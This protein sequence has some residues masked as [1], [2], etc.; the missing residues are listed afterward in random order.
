MNKVVDL[1]FL[2][3]FWEQRAVERKPPLPFEHEP[4]NEKVK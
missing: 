3:G 2:G 1:R 4:I